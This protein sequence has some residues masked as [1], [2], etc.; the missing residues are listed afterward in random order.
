M[1]YYDNAQLIEERK[2][3]DVQMKSFETEVQHLWDVLHVIYEDGKPFF[4]ITDYGDLAK[5]NKNRVRK[6][7][8]EKS[9]EPLYED[10]AKVW[11]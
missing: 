11:D 6:L 5:K 8:K 7:I 9:G 4:R 3:Y 10:I 1:R 2:S